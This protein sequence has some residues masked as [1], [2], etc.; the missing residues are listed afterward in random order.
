MGGGA[1]GIAHVGVLKAFNECGFPI[2]SISGSSVGAIVGALYASGLSVLD[3]EDIVDNVSITDFIQFK[4]SKKALFSSEAIERFI[5]SK[6][7]DISFD[8]CKIP[9]NIAATNILSGKT[10]WLCDY[11]IP[12]A[13]AVRASASIPGI[14]SP[15]KIQDAY[16]IDGSVTAHLP[17][18][19]EKKY[20][21][22]IGSNVIPVEKLDVL[23]ASLYG[24]VDR[25]I[26]CLI[27]DSMM[28][29]KKF[30]FTLTPLLEYI[31]SFEFKS[32]DKLMDWGYNSVMKHREDIKEVIK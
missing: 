12:V 24:I 4:L 7:G 26:D 14:F 32:R 1:R 28:S 17:L 25:A 13:K 21:V 16:F 10:E 20:E 15:T 6:I 29:V 31:G 27:N 19:I 2:H 8:A 3:L 5:I 23:P 22:V 11:S 9:L 18:K 30:D